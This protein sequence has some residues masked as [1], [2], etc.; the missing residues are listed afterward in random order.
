MGDESREVEVDSEMRAPTLSRKRTMLHR[1]LTFVTD[2]SP[3]DVW[4]TRVST[5]YSLRF[6]TEM[7]SGIAYITGSLFLRY[8]YNSL[9][10]SFEDLDRTVY[11]TVIAVGIDLLCFAMASL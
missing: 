6:V 3:Y 8:G 9:F 4:I 2:P 11:F 1:T 5:D 7:T 10:Y